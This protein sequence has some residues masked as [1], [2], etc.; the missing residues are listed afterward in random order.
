[1]DPAP[2]AAAAV[3][4]VEKESIAGSAADAAVEALLYDLASE[5]PLVFGASAAEIIDYFAPA[6]WEEA[7]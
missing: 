7:I 4:S 1:V 6:E 3:K 2:V 5:W